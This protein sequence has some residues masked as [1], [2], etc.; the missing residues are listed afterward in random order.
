MIVIT[1][2]GYVP[3]FCDS[4]EQKDDTTVFAWV[5]DDYDGD[6]L[7]ACISARALHDQSEIEDFLPILE[8]RAQL[9]YNDGIDVYDLSG[10][11]HSST[12]FMGF[13]RGMFGD[14]GI[15]KVTDEWGDGRALGVGFID[16]EL[17]GNRQPSI[18]DRWQERQRSRE[19]E[20]REKL[21][22]DHH[23]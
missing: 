10:S 21:R 7:F 3:D 14:R 22:W 15:V 20:R 9:L 8:Y 13:A 5:D 2:D 23:I 19:A 11:A 1:E 18:G 6:S 16:E 4:T 12:G 17:A